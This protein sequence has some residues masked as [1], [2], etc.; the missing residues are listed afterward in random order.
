MHTFRTTPRV[1]RGPIALSRLM[2]GCGGRVDSGS[3]TSTAAP[4]PSS[5]PSPG[6]PLASPVACGPRSRGRSFLVLL[7]VAVLGFAASC[8]GGGGTVAPPTAPTV[9]PPPAPP[10]RPLAWRGVPERIVIEAGQ[11]P[12]DDPYVV[13]LVSG[14]TPV[15]S[16]SVTTEL[17]SPGGATIRVT[18]GPNR[19]EYLLFVTAESP[20]EW[21]VE[22]RA[23]LEG[24][25][26]ARAESLLVSLPGFDLMFWRQFGFDAYDCPTASACGGLAV[27]ERLLRVL[28]QV[29][30]FYIHS[31]GF[32]SAEVQTITERIPRAAEQLTGVPFQASIEI[33]TEGSRRAGQVLIRGLA[34]DD[35][36]W[37]TDE[38]PCGRAYAGA[39]AGE[40]ELNLECVRVS[41][42]VFEELISHELGHA[43]GFFHVDPPHVMQL[44]DWLGRADF[45]PTEMSHAVLSYSLGR[46]AP[47]SENPT[48]TTFTAH[49]HPPEAERSGGVLISCYR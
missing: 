33:G 46:G 34:G 45:T 14:T 31:T 20:G 6:S 24:H 25:E 49:Q 29:P 4:S 21:R 3:P 12:S 35:E 28:P 38:P 16:A 8:G 44:E 48:G 23:S 42:L 30:D 37:G 15:A 19:G 36:E 26:D 40:V 11:P 27:E 9:G 41:K 2:F 32:T 47:Y 1:S 43:F 39:V 5:P 22:L 13:E 7:R 18:E 17:D 10:L